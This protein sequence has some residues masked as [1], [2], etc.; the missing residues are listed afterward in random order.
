MKITIR[1]KLLGLI[2]LASL[3]LMW[4]GF[5]MWGNM[6]QAKRMYEEQQM[7]QRALMLAER[8]NYKRMEVRSIFISALSDQTNKLYGEDLPQNL[9]RKREAIDQMGRDVD[10]LLSNPYIRS[11]PKEL[12]MAEHL[13]DHYLKWR[14]EHEEVDK[15]LWDLSQSGSRS[16]REKVYSGG[17]NKIKD[18]FELSNQF[19]EEAD[20]FVNF[21]TSEASAKAL[22]SAERAKRSAVMSIIGLGIIITAIMSSGY[23]L[24]FRVSSVI[25]WASHAME[26]I[27]SRS[28]DLTVPQDFLRRSDEVGDIARS[29]EQLLTALREQ[30]SEMGTASKTLT[31]TSI[32]I[33]STVSQVAA[34]TEEN[35]S[36]ITESSTSMEEIK[37]TARSTA[38]RMEEATQL[39]RDG[40][41]L[42]IRANEAVT[43]LLNSLKAIMERMDFISGTIV[44]LN[45]RSREIMEI[46]DTVEDLADQSNLLAVNAA[47]EAARYSDGGKG[48]AVVAQEIKEL[49]EQSKQSAKEV[50]HKLE[51][52]L[53]ATSSAVMATEQ[54][55]KAVAEAEKHTEPVKNSMDQMARQLGEIAQMAGQILKA[56]QDLFIGVDQ[57]NLAL[58]QIRTAS[59][60]NLDAMKALESSAIEL[61]AQGQ[62]LIQIVNEY[63][64]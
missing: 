32:K 38:K 59:K 58:E 63:K 9:R 8:I 40:L 60:E 43:G 1:I 61:K 41:D 45:D 2:T 26:K 57:V 52:V 5:T 12:S 11:N 48:F 3:S 29:L 23:L 62:K 7:V 42:V 34:S 49:A 14:R 24:A 64:L 30:I 28:I 53:R 13:R 46:A 25:R 50:K 10:D 55:M 31:D 54:G 51:E 19:G 37:A 56:N 18:L 22:E 27:A 39:S 4:L 44:K 36:A 21:M 20:A 33:S 17:M 47:V 16:S 6:V 35:Y 15:I